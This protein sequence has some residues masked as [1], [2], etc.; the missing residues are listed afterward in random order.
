MFKL[1]PY[2]WPSVVRTEHEAIALGH[3]KKGWGS[4]PQI[5]LFGVE[6][7]FIWKRESSIASCHPS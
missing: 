4:G 5:L 3:P 1:D 2:L 7:N 6:G